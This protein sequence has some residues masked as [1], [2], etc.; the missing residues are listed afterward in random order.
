MIVLRSSRVLVGD[1][2][3]V[4]SGL[5]ADLIGEVV[6]QAPRSRELVVRMHES[7]REVFLDAFD[8]QVVA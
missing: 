7:G 2:V 5:N 1:R 3:R 6:R 8:L 4:L